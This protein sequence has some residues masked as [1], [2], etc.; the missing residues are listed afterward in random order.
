MT[1]VILRQCLGH[2]LTRPVD[3]EEILGG[4]QWVDDPSPQLEPDVFSE[5]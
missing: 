3:S 4:S 5:S 1:Y 2:P